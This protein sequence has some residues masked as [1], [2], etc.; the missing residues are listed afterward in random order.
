M[1]SADKVLWSPTLAIEKIARMGHPPFVMR[2]AFRKLWAGHTPNSV[3]SAF[4]RPRAGHKPKLFYTAGSAWGAGSGFSWFAK[5]GRGRRPDQLAQPQKIAVVELN[6][7]AT[8]P[9]MRGL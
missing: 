2:Q 7:P 9:M 8:V 3:R 4:K 1:D 6:R 5:S